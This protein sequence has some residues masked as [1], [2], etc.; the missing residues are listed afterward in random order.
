MKTIKKYRTFTTIS[1]M[2]QIAD[3]MEIKEVSVVTTQPVTT[4]HKAIK[5]ARNEL[6]ANRK[7]SLVVLNVKQELEECNMDEE[8]FFMNARKHIV[9]TTYLKGE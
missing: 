8:Y 3:T 6:K 2:H 9:K 1:L 7:D 5:I 4:F